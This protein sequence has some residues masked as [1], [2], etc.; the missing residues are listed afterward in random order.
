MSRHLTYRCIPKKRAECTERETERKR[1]IGV[2]GLGE[3]TQMMIVVDESSGPGNQP[4]AGG[5]G[6]GR[7]GGEG[8]LGVWR[9]EVFRGVVV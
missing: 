6:G 7:D 3:C 4:G 5:G 1:E 2:Q 9:I 8:A